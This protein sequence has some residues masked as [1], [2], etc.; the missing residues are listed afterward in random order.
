MA[1]HIH[2]E[3]VADAPSRPQSGLAL[4]YFRQQ[5]VGVQAPLHQK[6][7]LA[8]ANKLHGL[9]RGSLTMRHVDDFDTAEV[10]RKFLC[11]TNN[12]AL[13]TH[14]NWLDQ[15]SPACLDR[16]SEGT[17]VARVRHSG[18]NR[19]QTLRSGDQMVVFLVAS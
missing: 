4:H 9:R 3:D 19:L 18:R 12:L 5:L 2:D 10:E 1:R 14:K 16:A 13:G 11:D 6:L 7:G 15:S 17:L 8:G